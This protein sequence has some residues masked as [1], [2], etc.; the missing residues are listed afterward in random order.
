MSAGSLL[1]VVIPALDE[2]SHLETLLEDLARVLPTA[3][4]VVVDGGSSDDTVGTARRKGVRTIASRP[5][6]APQMNA[7]AELGESDWLLFLHAD[8]RLDA[9][10]AKALERFIDAA[11]H[12]GVSGAYFEFALDSDAGLLS[13]VAFGQRI[14]ERLTGLVY[15]DQGLLVSRAAFEAVGGYPE[16]PLME[17]VEMIRRLRRRGRL[18]RLPARLR[19]SARRYRRGG[20]VRTSLRNLTLITAYHLGIS[21]E[22]LARW[23]PVEPRP[24]DIA[25]R[26]LLV[27]AKLPEPGKVKT[28]LART[29]GEVKAAEIYSTLARGVIQGVRGGAYDVVVCYDPPDR[30]A[31]VSKWLDK[32]DIQLWPQEPGDLGTRMTRAFHRA[33]AQAQQVCIIGTDA[34]D[35]DRSTVET[36]F[37]HLDRVPVVL[38]PALDGGYYLMALSAPQPDLFT[39]IDWSTDR[40]AEQTRRKAA[41][42]GLALEELAVLTD[43]DEAADVPEDLLV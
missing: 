18:E 16:Q 17:D 8:C 7:G 19:T 4:V 20:V 15:G 30:H 41:E 12:A 27:F 33:F 38:G 35:V 43:V 14:R 42:L 28:R 34:P 1:S 24:Q 23:Y 37:S 10:A 32:G 26:I 21:A 9:H 11:P 39:G 36:A 13:A 22:R 29:L 6:R 25:K 40:V 2:A 31:E 3:D 5:G